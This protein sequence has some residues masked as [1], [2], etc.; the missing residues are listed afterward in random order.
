MISHVSPDR[1]DCRTAGRSASWF[2]MIKAVVVGNEHD[3][4]YRFY[5]WCK[6]PLD[7]MNYT[8]PSSYDEN[9][10]RM[11]RKYELRNTASLR[12]WSN[13]VLPLLPVGC[14]FSLWSQDY[15]FSK[16]DLKVKGTVIC[17]KNEG[18]QGSVLLDAR[19]KGLVLLHTP[20]LTNFLPRVSAALL[21]TPTKCLMLANLFSFSLP[22]FEK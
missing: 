2:P 6:T 19:D 3:M 13:Q 17:A 9:A 4:R 20:R 15:V 18:Q 16:C 10:G 1:L 8:L 14:G 5:H 7:G 12:V 22:R 11:V 21:L